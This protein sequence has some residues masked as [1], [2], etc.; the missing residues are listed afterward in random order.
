MILRKMKPQT[1]CS[2]PVS[3]ML[4]RLKLKICM[5][6]I[7]LWGKHLFYL[8]AEYTKIYR[9]YIF[10]EFNKLKIYMNLPNFIPAAHK[11]SSNFSSLK[12]CSA[13]P[14][15]YEIIMS[16]YLA[17]QNECFNWSFN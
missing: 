5:N 4:S 8:F 6:W 9:L 15:S 12:N 16:L 10:Q 2:A 13:L 3:E 11:G 7:N 1:D 17:P 14:Y